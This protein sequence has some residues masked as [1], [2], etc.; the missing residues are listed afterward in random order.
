MP[1]LLLKIINESKIKHTCGAVFKEEEE[2]EEEKK[3][4]YVSY[5]PASLSCF[6]QEYVPLSYQLYLEG[7]KD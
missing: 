6:H 3:R 7:E 1:L 4:L 2:E 5:I